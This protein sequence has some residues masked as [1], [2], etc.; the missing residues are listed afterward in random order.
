[1][2]IEISISNDALRQISELARRQ[3]DWEH[4]I[5]RLED[6]QKQANEALRKIQEEDLPAAMAEAG[7]KSFTLENGAKITVKDEVAVSIP[8]DRKYEAYKWLRDNGY[9]DVIKHNV[10]VEF[11]KED[12]AAALRLMEYCQKQGKHAEDQQSVHA[13]TLK[14]LVKEQLAKGV[15]IPFDLFGAY[16]Y[17]KAVIK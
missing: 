7:M 9:G 16:P 5:E 15:E 4:E 10:V 8:K 12:D 2:S 14:A 11:G 6:L 3:L 13:Q 17:S 1:M